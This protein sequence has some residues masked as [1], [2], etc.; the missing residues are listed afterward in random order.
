[1]SEKR[2]RG[3]GNRAERQLSRL[4]RQRQRLEKEM[5]LGPTAPNNRPKI[6]RLKPKTDGQRRYARA[7]DENRL[8]F[9]LGPAGTGKTIVAAGMAAQFLKAGR[10]ERIVCVRPAVEAADT[11]GKNTLG[12]LP[13]DKDAK[14]SPYLRPLLAR[15]RK[16]FGEAEFNKLRSG[17]FPVIE[18]YPLEHVRGDDFENCFVILDEAQNCTPGQLKMFITRLA[19]GSTMVIN[20]DVNQSDLPEEKQGGLLKYS[21]L[22]EDVEGVGVVEMTKDD[23]VRD[24][25]LARLMERLD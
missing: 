6:E 19:E 9:C 11:P 21:A 7:I 15:L 22:W 8:I 2:Y 25:F 23:I 20:G 13:G 1:M 4:E 16:F 18:L 24:P 14:L 17:E 3:K 5:G 12:Y 10:V